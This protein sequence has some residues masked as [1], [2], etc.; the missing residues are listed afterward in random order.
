LNICVIGAGR[1]GRNHI[2]TLSEM[3]NLGGIVESNSETLKSFGK[4]Y[5]NAKLFTDL[6]TAIEYGFDGFALATPAETHFTMGT[7]LI[8]NGCNVLIE[9]PLALNLKDAKKLVELANDNKTRLMVGHV[10][11]F[12]PAIQKMKEL[13]ESEK[14]GKLQYIYSNRLNLGTVRLQENVFWSFAP[15][16]ISIFNHFTESLPTKIKTFGGAFIQQG[17]HDT[18]ITHLE[19]PN[20]VKTHIFVSW[21]HPFKEHRIVII[22]SKGMVSFEDSSKDKNILFYEKGVNWEDGVPV[23]KNGPTE[24]ISYESNMPLEEE[25]KYFIQNLDGEIKVSNGENGLEVVKILEEASKILSEGL[26]N[27]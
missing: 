21:L 13:I 25:L 23:T 9:K 3:G 1:W 17:N 10:L 6:P 27:E 26:E 8:E 7:K 24:I 11:L 18:T 4:T 12:H 22:G 5:P 15:H 16:D 2:R 20:N 19:Y 14:I